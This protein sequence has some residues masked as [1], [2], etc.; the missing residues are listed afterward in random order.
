M[1]VPS[2]N[3]WKNLGR[4]SLRWKEDHSDPPK[5]SQLAGPLEHHSWNDKAFPLGDVYTPEVL[6]LF[7]TKELDS[8]PRSTASPRIENLPKLPAQGRARPPIHPQSNHVY[9]KTVGS[10]IRVGSGL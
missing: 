5:P 1:P 2:A 8:Q 10:W 9:G 4:G 7:R 3:I 6:P